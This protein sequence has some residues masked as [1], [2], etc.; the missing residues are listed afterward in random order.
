N[1]WT[2]WTNAAMVV[3]QNWQDVGI[4]ASIVTP[5]FGT[6]FADLQQANYDVSMGWATYVRTPW[7]YYRNLFDSSLVTPIDGGGTNAAG[8]VWAR[9][10]DSRADELLKAFTQTTDDAEQKAII[11]ELQ[12]FMVENVPVIP[13]FGNCYWYEWNTRRFVGFPTPDNWYAIGSPWEGDS[14]GALITVL[15]LHCKDAT[16]CGQQ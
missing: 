7:D 10:F 12:M 13:L 4:N 1:G 5:E 14:G 6:W 11:A 3:A 8:N 16:S 15:N 2:D 9:F